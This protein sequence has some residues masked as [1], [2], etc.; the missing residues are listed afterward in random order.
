M[1]PQIKLILAAII[2]ALAFSSGWVVKGW[3][4][5]KTIAE[6]KLDAT[7]QDLKEAQKV[8]GDMAGFQ[9]GFTDALSNFQAGNSANAKA[10]QELGTLILDVRGTAAGLRGDFAK[11]P[12]RITDAARPALAE[13]ATTCTA[14]F[15]AMAAAGGRLAEGGAGIARQAE[16]HA[17]DA[18]LMQ[19]AWPKTPSRPAAGATQEKYERPSN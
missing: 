14:V 13:Y 15:E 6:L 4:A 9:K 2:A 1:N 17:A 5:S 3:Q 19:E 8:L 10:Q 12:Q 16:G 18:R 11:L 7:T